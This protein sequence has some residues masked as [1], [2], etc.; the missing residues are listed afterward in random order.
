LHELSDEDLV[1][2]RR[3]RREAV[4]QAVITEQRRTPTRDPEKP[5]WG[6]AVPARQARFHAS[7]CVV[8]R[9]GAR[10][11]R[12]TNLALSRQP[13]RLG[14]IQRPKRRLQP[15]GFRREFLKLPLDAGSQHTQVSHAPQRTDQP[16]T[17]RS[18]P[19][20]TLRPPAVRGAGSLQLSVQRPSSKND[21][22][23][24][25]ERRGSAS[26]ASIL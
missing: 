7:R 15:L 26:L 19:R 25:S 17:H 1:R 8:S 14:A 24:K 10:S 4:R 13:R 3:A 6:P 2:D 11:V 22:I 23:N 5:A 21:L 9:G 12:A 18:G 20:S 16:D